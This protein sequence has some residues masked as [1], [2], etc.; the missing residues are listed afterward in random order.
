VPVLA[1][2]AAVSDLVDLTLPAPAPELGAAAAK[3]A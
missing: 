3:E 1:A 2:L